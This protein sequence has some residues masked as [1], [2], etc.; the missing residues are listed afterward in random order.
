VTPR[1][2][3]TELESLPLNLDEPSP[4]SVGPTPGWSLVEPV[5]PVRARGGGG[6]GRRS[7][8]IGAASLLIGFA[9]VAVAV[10]LVAAGPSRPVAGVGSGPSAAEVAGPGGLAKQACQDFLSNLA[11]RLDIPLATLEQAL[12]GAASDTIDGLVQGGSLTG[13]MATKLKDALAKVAAAPCTWSGRAGSGFHPF[14]AGWAPFTRG[15]DRKGSVAA[16]DQQAILDAAASALRTDRPTLESEI[17]ALAKGE[18]LRTIAT[19]HGVDYAT[20]TAAIHAAA[21]AQLDAAMTKGTITAD[22]ETAA[23]TRLDEGLAAGRIGLIGRFI[24]FMGFVG[25]WGHGWGGSNPARPDPSPS[26]SGA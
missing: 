7:V 4:G 5:A 12:S 1:S 25:G 11:T 17:K 2:D 26:A 8:A 15:F 14:S 20:L 19:K 16:L 24:G 3:D 13:D 6:P 18:D 22:Q 10:G 21:K 23:L 9:V